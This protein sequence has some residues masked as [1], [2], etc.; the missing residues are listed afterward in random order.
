[1][2]FSIVAALCSRICPAL[3][4]LSMPVV[5]QAANFTWDGGAS[6]GG[7]TVSNNWSTLNNWVAGAPVSADDTGIVFTASTV[8]TT[9]TQNIANPFLLNTLTF[10]A[11]SNVTAI[12][13]NQLNFTSTTATL[14]PPALTQSSSINVV[15]SNPILLSGQLNIGGTGSGT[16]TL[17]GPI[18]GSPTGLLKNGPGTLILSG[19]NTFNTALVLTGGVVELGSATALGSGGLILFAGDGILRY[20][21]ASAQTDYSSRFNPSG[22]QKIQVDTNG[23][24]VTFGAAIQGSN[25]RIVKSGAGTLTLSGLAP[26]SAT[27]TYQILGG[28]LALAKV[29][30]APAISGGLEIGNQT[31]PGAP[32]N[33]IVRQLGANQLSGSTDVTLHRDGVL[34]LGDFNGQADDVTMN[35]GEIRTNNGTLT[36]NGFIIA[37]GGS[38]ANLITATTANGKVDFSGGSRTI[39]ATRGTS[40]YDLDVR[41]PL[42]NGAIFVTG[43]G[44][45][46]LSAPVNS[47]LVVNQ[48]NGTLAIASDG[49][50]GSIN[51]TPSTFTLSGGTVVADGGNRTLGNPITITNNATFGESVD[52]TPHSLTFTGAGKLTTSVTV[53]AANSAGAALGSLELGANALTVAGNG[54]LTIAGAI[55]GTGKIVKNGVGTLTLDGISTFSGGLTVNS[56]SVSAKSGTSIGT[57][58]VTL[59]NGAS[60]SFTDPAATI[61]QTFQ[62][63]TSTLFPAVGGQLAYNGA[64]VFF[65]ALGAGQHVFAGGTQLETVRAVSGAALSQSGGTVTF[66]NVLLTGTSSFTQAAGSTLNTTG[67]FTANPA[68]SFTLNGTA[69]TLGASFSGAVAIHAGATLANSGDTLFLVGSQGVSVSAN[70]TLSTTAGTAIEVGTTLV[71]NG[72]QT[73]TLHVNAGGVLK[74]NGSFGDTTL[75]VGALLSPGNLLGTSTLARLTL[76]PGAELQFEFNNILATAGN[77]ADFLN[78]TGQLDLSAGLSTAGAFK[79]SLVSLTNGGQLGAISGFDPLAPF[80]L[81]FAAADG[82]I[83][84]FAPGAFA[85]DLGGFANNLAGGSFQVAQQGNELRLNFV[86]VPEPSSFATCALGSLLAL[87][88]RKRRR[89]P[90]PQGRQ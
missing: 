59:F 56:G 3:F 6:H 14:L 42:N 15:I 55:T 63:N 81:L 18:S 82:G 60:L 87:A 1:M 68:T 41:A 22:P 8:Q 47:G 40:T 49:A 48:F 66:G 84:G 36:L 74:G 35:G 52:G 2:K 54:N 79:L 19:N 73:G 29:S 64:S 72:T 32:G 39:S 17:S 90:M 13:G 65:G 33:V 7:L 31:N 11:T 9:A 62:L 75:G 61:T 51:L 21:A 34:D 24:D 44:V 80:S 46:R 23:Q 67:D 20:T 83:T 89:T 85:I 78:I 27:G 77:G 50:L 38:T 26:N 76:E 28:T 45:L 58:T 57:N 30:P 69:N 10:D 43:A 53:T 25:T 71:N 4:V 5:T 86:P 37:N 16:L 12:S 70:G 88:A